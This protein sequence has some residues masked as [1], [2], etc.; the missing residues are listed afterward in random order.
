MARASSE[1]GFLKR[2]NKYLFGRGNGELKKVNIAY[3][4]QDMQNVKN[5]G[6]FTKKSSRVEINFLL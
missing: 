2:V 1:N 6:V 3:Q 5:Q 4:L